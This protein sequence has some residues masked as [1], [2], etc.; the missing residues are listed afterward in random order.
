ML[1]AA[2]GQVQQEPQ[3]ELLALEQYDKIAR[4][5]A[6]ALAQGVR[7]CEAAT[8]ARKLPFTR[9][10]PPVPISLESQTNDR[11]GFS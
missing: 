3:P 7:V 5:E 1:P 9:L 6:A 2:P 4:L 8:H 11:V 10:T